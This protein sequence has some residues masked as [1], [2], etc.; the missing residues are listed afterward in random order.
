VNIYIPYMC[1][2]KKVQKCEDYKIRYDT[3][4]AHYHAN[5]T[6]PTSKS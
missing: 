1:E 6:G 5:S 4:I 3:K 2:D